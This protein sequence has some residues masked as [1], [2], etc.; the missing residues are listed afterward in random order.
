MLCPTGPCLSPFD[1]PLYSVGGLMGGDLTSGAGTSAGKHRS[2]CGS[3]WHWPQSVGDFQDTL[4]LLPKEGW[5]NSDLQRNCVLDAVLLG[6]A[7]AKAKQSQTS[8]VMSSVL[9]KT[10]SLCLF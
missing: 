9:M 6:T 4:K 1:L 7:L 8:P 10:L 5:S 3:M 2:Q